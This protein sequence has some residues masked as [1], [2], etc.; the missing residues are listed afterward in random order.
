MERRS[1]YQRVLMPILVVLGVMILSG[2]IYDGSRRLENRSL[3]W[4]LSHIG[5]LMLFLSLWLGAFFGNTLAFFKG[6]SF[7]E[8]IVVCLATPV[9]W[10]AQVLYA[11]VGIFSL[12]EIFFLLFHHFILGCLLV[13]LLC[14]ALSDIGCRWVYRRRSQEPNYPVF[15][16]AAPPGPASSPASTPTNTE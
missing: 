6:A 13:A 8:R 15:A 7:G 10:C 5:A 3:H 16:C 4:V 14:M 11:F 1:V 12:G 2:F 9:V